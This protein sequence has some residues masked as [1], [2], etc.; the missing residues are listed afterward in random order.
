MTLPWSTASFLHVA[1]ASPPVREISPTRSPI[2]L[3]NEVHHRSTRVYHPRELEWRRKGFVQAEAPVPSLPALLPPHPAHTSCPVPQAARPGLQPK[4]QMFS[5]PRPFLACDRPSLE[6]GFL[7]MTFSLSGLHSKTVLLP[8]GPFW[9][10]GRMRSFS[11][12]GL[13]C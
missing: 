3:L 5:T 2:L 9:V 1:G 12:W 4:P 11:V 6:L 7:S 13:L 8:L 10:L